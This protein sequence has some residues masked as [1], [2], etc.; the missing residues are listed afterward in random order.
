MSEACVHNFNPNWLIIR[1]FELKYVCVFYYYEGWVPV[2]SCNQQY[3]W[4]A[5]VVDY[6]ARAALVLRANGEDEALLEIASVPLTE[7]MEQTLEL[8]GTNV[9]GNP[10]GECYCCILCNVMN[11]L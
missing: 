8:I 5:S 6:D 2:D 10:Y 9:N 1:Y 4:H 3:C 7:L 11:S